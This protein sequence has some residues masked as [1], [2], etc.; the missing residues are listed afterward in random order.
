MH[1]RAPR[2]GGWRGG[3][4]NWKRRYF[5]LKDD[6]LYYYDTNTVR[7]PV[8]ATRARHDMHGH[9]LQR[10][11]LLGLMPLRSAA[12]LDLSHDE[13]ERLVALAVGVNRASLA[14]VRRGAGTRMAELGYLLRLQAGVRLPDATAPLSVGHAAYWL[15]CC[16]MTEP[17]SRRSNCGRSFCDADSARS[18][19]VP[20]C[21]L[22]GSCRRA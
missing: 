15:C 18:I 8:F 10:T 4:Q 13:G 17:L 12:V 22:A 20:R 11:T 7:V 16:A 2:A 19:E 5:V 3:R 9:A 21:A 1:A 6:V 14:R